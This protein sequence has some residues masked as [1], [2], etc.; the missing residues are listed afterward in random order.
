MDILQNANHFLDDSYNKVDQE[1][2]KAKAEKYK[3]YLSE[4]K[5]KSEKMSELISEDHTSLIEQ[6]TGMLKVDD[7]GT[8][9]R[10]R[11]QANGLFGE[12]DKYL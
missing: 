11:S 6:A 12:A 10:S 9:S 2:E 4:Q 8:L 5:E 1:K 3:K 7:S